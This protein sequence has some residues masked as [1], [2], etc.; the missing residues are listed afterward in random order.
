[1]KEYP[2]LLIKSSLHASASKNINISMSEMNQFIELLKLDILDI[3]SNKKEG[4]KYMLFLDTDDGMSFKI[5]GVSLPA[6]IVNRSFQNA[7]NKMNYSLSGVIEEIGTNITILRDM[8]NGDEVEYSSFIGI[9]GL[10]LKDTKEIDFGSVKIRQFD[11]IASP[12][13]FTNDTVI[14]LNDKE[15]NYYGGCVLEIKHKTKPINNISKDD[16]YQFTTVGTVFEDRKHV[17]DMFN[18]S[19]IFALNI[20]R[21]MSTT[22]FESGFPLVSVGNF[23]LLSDNKPKA[24]VVV[25]L[26]IINK[27]KMWFEILTNADT[28]NVRI[29]LNRLRLAIFE[30][31]SIEDSILDAL[32]AWEG[33][34]S[35]VGET[36]F[37]T[38]ASIANY[39]D[40]ND[41]AEDKKGFLKRLKKL[42][43]L[44]SSIVHGSTPKIKI[45]NIVR[46]EVI[47]IGLDCVKKI[48][49]NDKMIKLKPSARVNKLL[50]YD[51]TR[52]NV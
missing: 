37:K 14:L 4:I 15:T 18:F 35:G 45:D 8:V 48:L 43:N 30:R 31:N 10:V 46:S 12:N 5:Q 7:C 11:D 41:Y 25:E 23:S 47:K 13:L 32:I 21:A 20:D 33:I 34:F 52:N 39:I 50:I 2:Y 42:Y 49:K 38:T 3:C 44:R 9:K 24:M 19:I 22:F 16:L 29:S 40:Y 6:I 28:N 17:I 27:I 26:S 36:T 1:M 51:S